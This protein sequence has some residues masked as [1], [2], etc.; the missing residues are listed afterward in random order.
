M[1]KRRQ[2]RGS[3]PNLVELLTARPFVNRAAEILV[4]EEDRLVLSVPVRKRW[5]N[6][7]F[8]R[9]LLPTRRFKNFELDARGRLFLRLCDGERTVADIVE[10]F[11]RE[12]GLS[13]LE[14]RIAVAAFIE[15]LL[16]KGV[17]ALV[18]VRGD[19]RQGQGSTARP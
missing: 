19:K 3:K 12:Y 5:W 15:L 6:T 13:L 18:G 1:A 4:D 11:A 16:Q 9:W 7:G 10:E 2:R 14:A 17:I 8:M